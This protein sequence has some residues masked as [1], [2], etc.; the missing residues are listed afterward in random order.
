MVSKIMKAVGVV[1]D[2]LTPLESEERRRVIDAALTLLGEK[3]V[4]KA[5]IEEP[6]EEAAVGG[7]YPPRAAGWLKQNNLSH[8]Q[9]ERVFHLDGERADVLAAI[10][11]G[12]NRDK[13][14]NAYLLV[15]LWHFLRTGEPK[16]SDAAAREFCT[17]AGFYDPTNHAKHFK[18]WKYVIKASDGQW[19]V[20]KPG[21]EAAAALVAQLA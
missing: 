15:G 19:I 13:V 21:L 12:A 9:I 2:E 20:T 6:E 16:F 3:A 14:Q 8:Q 17:E 7:S 18:G 11:G 4:A 1:V 5:A 10:P